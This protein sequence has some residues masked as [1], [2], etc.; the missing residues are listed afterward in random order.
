MK[1]K[2]TQIT[3]ISILI[4]LSGCS[5]STTIKPVETQVSNLCIMRNPK[6]LMDGFLPELKTQIEQHNINTIIVDEF[7][8]PKC[9]NKLEYTANW[10]WD[11]AMYL[12]YAELS[13]YEDTTLIGQAIYDARWGGR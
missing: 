3:S 9:T 11:L 12:T 6:V 2:I 8:K 5:I 4:I 13:V 7:S 10:G 1:R